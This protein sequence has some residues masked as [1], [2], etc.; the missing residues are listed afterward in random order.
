M[1]KEWCV[2]ST[3]DKSTQFEQKDIHKGTWITP[4]ADTITITFIERERYRQRVDDELEC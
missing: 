2:R 3:V 1:A 4:N